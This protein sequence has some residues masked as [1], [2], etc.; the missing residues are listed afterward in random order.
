MKLPFILIKM[1]IALASIP[2]NMTL[3]TR[4]LFNS[5][6]FYQSVHVPKA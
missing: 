2:F 3:L 6:Y 5:K 1:K 4:L